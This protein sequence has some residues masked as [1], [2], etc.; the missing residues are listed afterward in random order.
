MTSRH[1][2]N[3]GLPAR[4]PSSSHR[5]LPGDADIVEAPYMTTAAASLYCGFKTPS[6]IRKAHHEGRLVPVGRRGGTVGRVPER[7]KVTMGV[8]GRG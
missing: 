8:T 7:V 6:A 1:T 3:G 4:E 2:R 5:P